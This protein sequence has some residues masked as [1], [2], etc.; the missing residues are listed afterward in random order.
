[1]ERPTYA[2]IKTHISVDI[3]HS[4]WN[5]FWFFLMM[6]WPCISNYMNNNEHDA[7][8]IFSLLSYRTCTCFGSISSPS[9]WGRMYIRVCGKWYLVYFWD[10]ISWLGWNRLIVS[11]QKY[12][13]YHLPH[14]YILHPDDGLL[15]RPKYVDV[16]Q[17]NKLKIN[18]ASGLLLFI[19]VY[20][21]P[22]CYL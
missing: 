20:L 3:R 15:M 11:S 9:P 4:A 7:L 6:G 22:I 10:D 19:Y 2:Y 18:G 8:F 1:M 17:L 21:L 14:I 16:W 13:K 12:N 5:C